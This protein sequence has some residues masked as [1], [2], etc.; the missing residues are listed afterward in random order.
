MFFGKQNI[1]Y[2][3]RHG[4]LYMAMP[5]IESAKR[6]MG[7][8]SFNGIYVWCGFYLGR[9]LIHVHSILKI[10]VIVSWRNRKKCGRR[11]VA[12]PNGNGRRNVCGSR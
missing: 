11:T 8:G 2:L 9:S 10:V 7:A 4:D 5:K 3:A 6:S 1:Q 12:M